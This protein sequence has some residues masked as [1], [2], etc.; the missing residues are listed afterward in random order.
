MLAVASD[1]DDYSSIVIK[2]NVGNLTYR[3]LKSHKPTATL[4]FTAESGS[5]TV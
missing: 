3:K 5:K 4:V 1:A 2:F